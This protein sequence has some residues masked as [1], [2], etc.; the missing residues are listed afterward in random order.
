MSVGLVKG[1]MLVDLDYHEDSR[2]D[3]DLN[4]V[5]LGDRRLVEIQGAAEGRAF[6]DSELL[7]MLEVSKSACADIHARQRDALGL[8]VPVAAPKEGDR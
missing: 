2:A 4:V 8:D 6:D 1:E 5:R 7:S 3:L